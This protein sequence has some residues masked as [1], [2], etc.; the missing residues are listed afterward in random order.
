MRMQTLYVISVL[1]FIA[2]LGASFAT[3][4]HIRRGRDASQPLDAPPAE[5]SASAPNTRPAL[6][7]P[8]GRAD[9]TYFNKDS[10][11]LKDLT[12]LERMPTR[13]QSRRRGAHRPASNRA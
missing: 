11:D 10:G 5:S 1:S 9:W 3:L 13:R 4:R 8:E 12:Q 6:K 7:T 2:L